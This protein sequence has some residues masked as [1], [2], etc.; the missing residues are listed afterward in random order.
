MFN[1]A[2]HALAIAI[3]KPRRASTIFGARQ[4]PAAV[5]GRSSALQI[6]QA[7]T[8]PKYRR[9]EFYLKIDGLAGP[10]TGRPVGAGDR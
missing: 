10:R 3:V 7:A 2:P 1:D 5:P 4:A 9:G 6:V 8:P